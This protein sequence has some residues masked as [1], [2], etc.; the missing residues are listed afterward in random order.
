MGYR[1]LS[2]INYKVGKAGKIKKGTSEEFVIIYFGLLASRVSHF[3]FN[4]F[5]P[6]ITKSCQNL[7]FYSRTRHFVL[8][9]SHSN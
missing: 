6:D 7:S 1:F 9:R 8:W 4:S 2:L 3:G 5:I